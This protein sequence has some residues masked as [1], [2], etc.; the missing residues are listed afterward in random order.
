[1]DFNNKVV[2]IFWFFIISFM[3]YFNL[4]T[5]VLSILF[6]LLILT[7]TQNLFAKININIKIKKYISLLFSIFI[8][9][10][11]GNTLYFSF[12]LMATDL[13]ELIS[14][15]QPLIIK[16]FHNLNIGY[17]IKNLEDIFNIGLSYFKS[18]LNIITSSLTVFLQI[19]LGIIFAILLH[20]EEFKTIEPTNSWEYIV[21]KILFQTKLIF[22]NFKKIMTIQII[23]AILNTLMVSLLS[24]II[25]PLIYHMNLPYWY[26]L[27][28]LTFVLSFFP[29]VGNLL[30]NVI[31]V[32][33]TVQVSTIY[34]ILGISLFFLAHKM[35]LLIIGSKLKGKVDVNFV[36]ILFSMFI[37]ELIFNSFS[38]ILLGMIILTSISTILKNIKLNKLKNYNDITKSD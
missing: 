26:I 22:E 17:H 6:T 10:I 29:V 13:V 28:P 31:L 21:D 2:A 9:T 20:F 4:S 16:F 34:V 35:E 1:M 14:I 36:F 23:V 12:K 38:G 5:F 18:N 8:F 25:T 24:L 30:I 15:S 7:L 27:I 37:G 33:A 32:M 3:V 19:L 11:L